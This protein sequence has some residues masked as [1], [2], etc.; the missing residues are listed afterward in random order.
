MALLFPCLLYAGSI[1]GA[2]KARA[3]HARLPVYKA[4]SCLKTLNPGICLEAGASRKMTPVWEALAALNPCLSSAPL[5]HVYPVMTHLQGCGCEAHNVR[6][7]VLG[8][9]VHEAGHED[10]IGVVAAG[11]VDFIQHPHRHI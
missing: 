4:L 9:V 6:A 8:R 10:G 5:A 2:L 11:M 1:H 3:M 7:Q